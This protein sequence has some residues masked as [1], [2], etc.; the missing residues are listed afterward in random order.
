MEEGPEPQELLEQ[1]ETTEHAVGH[2]QEPKE[3]SGFNAQAALLASVL[4]VLAAI[5]SLL[6]GHSA[7][8]AILKQAESSNQWAFY[9]A[10][11]TKAHIFEGNETVLA[12]LALTANGSDKDKLLA[13]SREAKAQVGKYITEKGDIQKEAQKL[14]DL[15]AKAFAEHEKFSLAVACFQIGI[16]LSS[17]SILTRMRLLQ[18][19]SA[20]VGAV[21][22]VFTAM[23]LL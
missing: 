19:G 4:A 21:G 7:N 8:E 12:G 11:S 17:M 1:V 10:K 20:A 13:A 23:G 9:Q 16:V 22:L 5:G 3:K 6:S 14:A 18:V 2:H 15:S